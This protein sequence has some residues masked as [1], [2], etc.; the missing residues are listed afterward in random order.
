M[1][2]YTLKELEENGLLQG[3]TMEIRSGNSSKYKSIDPATYK[4]KHAA[5]WSTYYIDLNDDPK[6]QGYYI[7]YDGGMVGRLRGPAIT[8]D[9]LK[10]SGG[11][12]QKRAASRWESTGN[13]VYVK[14]RGKDGKL[15][16]VQRMVYVNAKYPGK[17]RIAKIK[18]GKRIY[19]AF[20]AA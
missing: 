8:P 16:V 9:Q 10:K 11:A 19:V 4:T 2:E 14:V 15:K 3:R 20:R 17:M 12:K 1:V 6:K 13:H 5:E 7:I 18:D